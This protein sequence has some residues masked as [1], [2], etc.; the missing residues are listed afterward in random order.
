MPRSDLL[1]NT[2]KHRSRT[3]RKKICKKLL[4]F[5]TDLNTCFAHSLWLV[6]NLQFRHFIVPLLYKMLLQAGEISAR[7]ITKNAPIVVDLLAH[8]IDE[9]NFLVKIQV[10]RLFQKIKVVIAVHVYA[11]HVDVPLLLPAEKTGYVVVLLAPVRILFVAV[12]CNT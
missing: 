7:Q 3:S 11:E 1:Y 10:F 5:Q 9:F 12:R 8:V 2:G 4:I 6:E